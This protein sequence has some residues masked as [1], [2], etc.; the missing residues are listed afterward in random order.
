MTNEFSFRASSCDDDL[1]TTATYLH[2]P[3]YQHGTTE[4]EYELTVPG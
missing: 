4:L 3:I 2:T 1:P